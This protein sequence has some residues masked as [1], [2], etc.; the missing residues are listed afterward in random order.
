MFELGIERARTEIG[1][2]PGGLMSS[3][4]AKKREGLSP[5]ITVNGMPFRWNEDG[6]GFSTHGVD[7]VLFWLKPS[8][9]SIIQ[10]LCEEIGEDLSSRL[11]AF[12]ASKGTFEDY[13][14][15]V[16]NMGERFEEGFLRWGDAVCAAGWGRF[17]ILEM[18]WNNQSAVVR[19]DQPWENK[20]QNPKNPRNRAPF[21]RGK[22][23]GIFSH[24]FK[25]NCRAEV[26]ASN[27]DDDDSF[28]TLQ[29]KPSSETLEQSL[30]Q[31]QNEGDGSEESRRRAVNNAIRRSQQRL[32]DVIETVGEFVWECD[33]NLK[34]TYATSKAG[35]TLR[36]GE[37]SP[38]GLL[39]SAIF[40]SG[41]F[42]KFQSLLKKFETGQR[43]VDEEFEFVGA[44]GESRWL[45]LRF[46]QLF[47]FSGKHCGFVGSGKDISM[48]KE[49]KNQLIEQQQNSEYAAKMATLGEMASG[50]AHEINTPLSV[51]A[52]QTEQVMDRLQEMG[53]NETGLQKSLD[54]ILATTDR[55][56]KII[57]GLRSFARDATTDPMSELSLNTLF[58][59]T[60][61]LCKNRMAT[62]GVKIEIEPVVPEIQILCRPAQIAQVLLNLLNNSFDAVGEL[63]DKWIQVKT[64]VGESVVRIRVTDSGPGIPLSIRRKLMQPFFTTKPIGKGTGLGLSISKGLLEAHGGSLV[65]DEENKHTSFIIELP[66]CQ[67][68]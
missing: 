66:R 56:A 8:L 6:T 68:H 31:M 40:S 4:A 26:I 60:M 53:T 67:R 59:E 62:Y 14:S 12:E 28:V 15:M 37:Q 65:L 45:L 20:V 9:L 41:E 23:S 47:D 43:F 1:L 57:Q 36:L 52:L 64:E 32:L 35:E 55:I 13:H 50:I 48:E 17:S 19:I 63:Q 33:L 24:A 38:E 7:S 18:D 25:T 51:I 27:M 2:F 49:L 46:K 5:H 30:L 58:D 39:W 10:P 22:V 42:L 29:V 61:I 44:G 16:T 54:T 3:S 21:L 11:I 34:I